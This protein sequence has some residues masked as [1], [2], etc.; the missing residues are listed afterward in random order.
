MA[1][2]L[3]TALLGGCATSRDSTPTIESA[4]TRPA[5]RQIVAPANPDEL[6]QI[7]AALLPPLVPSTLAG[8]APTGDPRFDLKVRDAPAN[9]VYQS[10]VSGTRYSLAVPPEMTEKISV[11]LAD[12]TVEGALQAIR[13][14]YGYEYQ[15]EGNRIA[16]LSASVQS[17]VFRVNYLV[18]QRVGAGE[19][20]VLAPDQPE[21]RRPP[22]RSSVNQGAVVQ[23][24]GNGVRT[25][26]SIDFWSDL[27]NTLHTMVGSADGRSVVVNPQAGIVVVRAMPVELRLIERYLNAIRDSVHR[28]VVLEAKIVEVTLGEK[29]QNGISWGLFPNALSA[30]GPTEGSPIGGLPG[31]ALFGLA[32]NTRSFDALLEFLGT[33]GNVQVLSSPRIAALN[34]QKALLKVGT[35]DFFVTGVNVAD[36]AGRGASGRAG[37]GTPNIAVRPFFNGVALDIT[38]QI[39]ENSGVILH[40]HPSVTSVTQS[41]RT[42]NLGSGIGPVTLPFASSVVSE[43]D[44][45]IRVR[46]SNIVVIGGLMKVDVGRVAASDADKRNAEQANS[47]VHGNRL[48]AKRELV[49]LLKPTVVMNDGDR[50]GV[51]VSTPNRE[52]SL[53]VRSG[54]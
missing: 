36:I 23:F 2:S 33:Q 18:G 9:E 51:F 12:V 4:Q 35:D 47:S 20:T 8:F 54:R 46:D 41:D 43:S 50:P 24:D 32:L 45:V 48:A 34:N 40:I 5:T 10:I 11:N 16:I 30:I 15:I 7:Q 27:N 28:Q 14:S 13:D 44:S 52:I 31:G 38:P 39:D 22:M 25:T 26:T 1:V 29:F 42:V 21:A 19:T 49:V 37:Q 53:P 6:L 17:R 3:G